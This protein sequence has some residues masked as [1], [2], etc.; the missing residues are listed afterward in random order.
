[1]DG[2]SEFLFG[3]VRAGILALLFGKPDEQ[4]YV[5]EI[6]RAI[7]AGQGSV[8]RELK[9]LWKAGLIFRNTRGN[10]V[11]YRANTECAVF[12]ELREIMLKTAALSD[13]LKRALTAADIPIDLALV[14]GSMAKGNATADSDV[15]L[16]IVSDADTLRLHGELMKVEEKLGRP[17]NYTVLQRDEFISRRKESGGFIERILNDS[18]IVVVGEIDEI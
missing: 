9:Q 6:V 7:N 17:I 5:R 11:Y 1:M 3:K 14:Y 8:Q 4:F 2:L 12:D 13:V 10:H 16:L 15:D 18:I